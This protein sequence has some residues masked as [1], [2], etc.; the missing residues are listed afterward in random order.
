MEVD[1]HVSRAELHVPPTPSRSLNFEPYG[2]VDL[3]AEVRAELAEM[4]EVLL[5]AV[6]E[7]V[8]GREERRIRAR[9]I[10]G[11][12]M[13]VVVQVLPQ[14]CERE[15]L[16]VRV[17]ERDALEGHED[18]ARKQGHDPLIRESLP[19]PIRGLVLGGEDAGRLQ[20]SVQVG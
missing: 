7:R 13:G 6:A 17:G 4:P 12:G 11:A 10:Q 3:A 1:L 8:I 15:V 14:M 18:V 16:P 20:P 19:K 2:H 5:E 9:E